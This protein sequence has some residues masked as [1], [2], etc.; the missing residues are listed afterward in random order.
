MANMQHI[1]S[2]TDNANANIIEHMGARARNVINEQYAQSIDEMFERLHKQTDGQYYT[3][4]AKAEHLS[5]LGGGYTRIGFESKQQR[6]AFVADMTNQGIEAT[7]APKA[8]G[9]QWLVEIPNSIKT[10]KLKEDGE[11]ARSV[12]NS[13]FT[14]VSASHIIDNFEQRTGVKAEDPT[15]ANRED[16]ANFGNMRVGYASAIFGKAEVLGSAINKAKRF[17]FDM[18]EHGQFDDR[19]VFT[20]GGNTEGRKVKQATVINGETVIVNG[21]VVTDEKTKEAILKRHEKRIAKAERHA[22]PADFIIKKRDGLNGMLAKRAEEK[23]RKVRK[24]NGF[25]QSFDRKHHPVFVSF[26]EG[27]GRKVYETDLYN[28]EAQEEL[29]NLL[30]DGGYDLTPMQTLQDKNG[31]TFAAVYRNAETGKKVT[32]VH[33]HKEAM[34]FRHAPLTA[35]AKNSSAIRDA[36]YRQ[37]YSMTSSY[38]VGQTMKDIKVSDASAEVLNKVY[39]HR[40]SKFS[41]AQVIALDNL[42]FDGT[43]SNLTLEEREN[44]ARTL[45]KEA[46]TIKVN[47]K[48]GIS[49]YT[50]Q[51]LDDLNK[52]IDE[53]K[54]SDYEEAESRRV[55]KDGNVKMDVIKIDFGLAAIE[56]IAAGLNEDFMVSQA[57][58]GGAIGQTLTDSEDVMLDEHLSHIT[59]EDGSAINLFE[60][61]RA[62]GYRLDLSNDEYAVLNK[63]IA[64]PNATLTATERYHLANA[65]EKYQRKYGKDLS[66]EGAEHLEGVIDA[67]KLGKEEKGSV[68]RIL[69]IQNDLGIPIS[70]A[71]FTPDK[72]LEMNKALLEKSKAAG[73]NLLERKGG[74]WVV[75]TEK[76][77]ALSPEM[78]K[79]IGISEATR[80]TMIKVNE[81]Q[82]GGWSNGLAGAAMNGVISMFTKNDEDAAQLINAGQKAKSA[83]QYTKSAVVNIRREN[84]ARKLKREAKR[85]KKSGYGKQSTKPNKKKKPKKKKEKVDKLLYNA[86]PEKLEKMTAKATKA[87]EKATKKAL[88]HERSMVGKFQ[89]LKAKATQKLSQTLL[90]K[91]VVGVKEL[92]SKAIIAPAAT[93]FGVIMCIEA[94]IIIIIIILMT[95]SAFLDSINP[96]NW[97]NNALAPDTYA[98]TVAYTLYD[99]YLRVKEEEWVDDDLRGF[100]K[101][102]DERVDMNY[103]ADYQDFQTY[104]ASFDDIVLKDDD[105]N[106]YYSNVYINPFYASGVEHDGI[107]SSGVDD[108]DEYDGTRT[109][110]IGCNNNAFS[111]TTGST[112]ASVDNAGMQLLNDD[113]STV[114]S[115]HTCNIKDILCM[116]DVMYGMDLSK[117]GEADFENDTSIMGKSP[118]QVSFEDGVENV[119]GFFKWLWNTIQSVNP[120]SDAKY[121]PLANFCNDKVGMKTIIKYAETLYESSHQQQ[122]ALEVQY[123]KYEPLVLQTNTGAVTIG[124][125]D[126]EQY[127]ASAL[128]YCVNPVKKNFYLKWN[129]GADGHGARVSPYFTSNEDG[130]G[131]QYITD[132]PTDESGY[133]VQVD[134]S[135]H[136]ETDPR[137]LC[138]KSDMGNNVET[139]NFVKDIAD[140]NGTSILD[141]CWTQTKDAEVQE[142]KTMA[143][144]SGCTGGSAYYTRNGGYSEYS[145]K[146]AAE[147]AVS[148]TEHS[149]TGGWYDSESA[150]KDAVKDRLKDKYD[151]AYIPSDSYVLSSDRNTFTKTFYEQPDFEVE[152]G[153]TTTHDFITG[154]HTESWERKW[155][156]TEASGTGISPSGAY[157]EDWCVRSWNSETEPTTDSN[158]QPV[159]YQTGFRSSEDATNWAKS[160][161]LSTGWYSVCCKFDVRWKVVNDYTTFY[162]SSGKCVTVE[163]KVDEFKR[164]CEGHGFEYCGGH[165]GIHSH[166]VVYSITNEQIALS[167]VRDEKTGNPLADDFDLAEKGYDMLKGKNIQRGD[168]KVDYSTAESASTSGGCASPLFDPQG[169]ISGMYGLNLNVEGGEW[170][171]GYRTRSS[172]SYH[173][174]RDIF[175]IDTLILKGD[176]IFPLQL[177]YHNYEGWS[178]DNMTLAILKW[179]ADWYE[180]YGFDIPQEIWCGELGEENDDGTIE[181]YDYG[182][183]GCGQAPLSQTDI[184]NIVNAVKDN[185]G[186]TIFND[187]REAA[188]RYALGFVGKGHYNPAHDHDFLSNACNGLNVK[189]R[190]AD[191]NESWVDYDGCCTT[192]TEE[193]F[194]NYIRRHFGKSGLS[195]RSGSAS[196][197]Y[198]TPYTY[199]SD[200]GTSNAYPA[201][202]IAHLPTSNFLDIEVP[203]ECGTSKLLLSI[204]APKMK[205]MAGF[206]TTFF[207][208][209]SGEDIELSTGQVIEAGAPITIDLTEF[210]CKPS[211]SFGNIYLH[212]RVSTENFFD[213]VSFEDQPWLTYDTS[214]TKLIRFN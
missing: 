6:D 3:G 200:A 133:K 125:S 166:G 162:H 206:K 110:T 211:I 170:V 126:I 84:E 121:E 136:V 4:E 117:M 26:N 135:N 205:E 85:A 184:D 103:G 112:S 9:G 72:I 191:G 111:K 132:L 25:A 198:P 102:Y 7:Y 40:S 159:W 134:M 141:Q 76:L 167:T 39:S 45:Q 30:A 147:D 192:G 178:E 75:S 209:I 197:K 33:K 15:P 127:A 150:A 179:A 44:L 105:G 58:L 34:Q 186:E 21:R 180:E 90:G 108:D 196:T 49:E 129:D 93:A 153:E 59:L 149:G 28:P 188:V 113:L 67:L 210:T 114:E 70:S 47:L 212:G 97:I 52:A 115:G 203:E 55:D 120:F 37:S 208:G 145:T 189:W 20:E 41:E 38:K 56:G 46:D 213:I 144:D 19:H 22:K 202:I 165:I 86:N 54:L 62:V 100:K 14:R 107:L 199:D 201:D 51:E 138:L 42:Y 88:K 190:D 18:S 74:K 96:I 155:Y 151:N 64:D 106:G 183:D 140:K 12:E 194:T 79:T 80:Q 98:D 176:N 1:R 27:L 130:T 139:Y 23:N 142:P 77:A 31:D 24:R 5:E 152:Y 57:K 11:V 101:M 61:V 187:E 119:V 99:D 94:V 35:V 123:H 143:M 214:R 124:Q 168:G 17:A 43:T 185:Y 83:Y 92:V 173:L 8:F 193:S 174:M 207:V 156:W 137:D 146:S 157:G 128:G 161:T 50:Q 122:V 163:K 148:F 29:G 177:D 36:A 104:F 89:T 160:H 116:T 158:G 53:I 204:A 154:W 66:A 87:Q 182:Y 181:P 2:A 63:I 175:D 69:G 78:L 171:D 169:S 172:N 73:V 118:E 60:D 32:V 71:N 109:V 10:E 195:G 82:I 16:E 131:D 164:D 68:E 65:T 48:E 91:L 81:A 13:G 95:I